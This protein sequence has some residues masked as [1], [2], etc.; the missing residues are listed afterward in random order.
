M[1][2]KLSIKGRSHYIWVFTNLKRI[3]YVYS[4]T[5]EAELVHK[6]LQGFSGV[7]VSD[8]Y[9]A[10][11]S[12]NCPQQKCL[13]HLIRDLNDDLQAEPYN[14]EMLKIGTDFTAVVSPIVETI[15]RFGLKARFLKKH[16]KSVDQFFNNIKEISFHTE[17]A[18][19]WQKRFGKN[20]GKLF[21]FMDYDAIPWNNNN[22]EH[23][24]KTVA[25]LRNVIGGSSTAEGIY[26]YMVLLSI[27]ETCKCNNLSFLDFLL[28]RE[29]DLSAFSNSKNRANVKID[30][31]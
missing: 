12:L 2:Q 10:Y 31:I 23:A 28:S 20:N 26:N 6:Y 15:D 18:T 22:A 11:D 8:F 29:T 5:R 13:I 3:F 21:T 27:S 14:N 7:L 9:A 30:I 19:K 25:L 17:I 16:K 4:E 24:V 1:K